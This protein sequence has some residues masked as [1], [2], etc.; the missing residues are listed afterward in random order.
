MNTVTEKVLGI[1]EKCIVE[2]FLAHSEGDS[3]LAANGKVF[4]VCDEDSFSHAIKRKFIK[5]ICSENKCNEEEIVFVLISWYEYANK[6]DPRYECS[7]F[8][9]GDYQTIE[10]FIKKHGEPNK[11][12]IDI[13]IVA[14]GISEMEDNI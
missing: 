13:D 8:I 9:D 12:E 11:N 14:H 10:N 6:K 3:I 7:D 2:I 4:T 1:K 5:K